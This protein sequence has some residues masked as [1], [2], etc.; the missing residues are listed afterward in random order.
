VFVDTDNDMVNC[1]SQFLCP[2]SRHA[3]HNGIADTT[4]TPCG[5]VV[6][7]ISKLCRAAL[8]V[9]GNLSRIIVAE[10]DEDAQPVTPR[11]FRPHTHHDEG[12]SDKSIDHLFETSVSK[13]HAET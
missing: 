7:S 4:T 9:D 2:T 10:R 11:H 12:W 13:T 1:N 6:I 8:R 3:D 5:A